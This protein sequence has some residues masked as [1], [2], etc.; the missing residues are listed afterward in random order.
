MIRRPPRSTLFPYTTLFRSLQDKVGPGFY[1]VVEK[2]LEPGEELRPWPVAG[3]SGYDT[4]NVI[5]GV[6]VDEVAGDAFER[7][8]REASG[9]QGSYEELLRQAKVE[10]TEKNFA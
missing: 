1:V 5:D 10:I 4:L 8:Y 6:L 2:I 9:L 7:I 3:T